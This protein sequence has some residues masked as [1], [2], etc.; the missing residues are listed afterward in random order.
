MDIQSM[1][2]VLRYGELVLDSCLR[3]LKVTTGFRWLHLDQPT[4][5]GSTKCSSVSYGLDIRKSQQEVVL[6]TFQGQY[7]IIPLNKMVK[8]R[9]K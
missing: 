4:T 7:Y 8:M 6:S 5:F 3:K 1:S 2:V 9:P